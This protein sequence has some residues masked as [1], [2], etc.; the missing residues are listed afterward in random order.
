M[1]LPWG[2]Y[3]ATTTPEADVAPAIPTFVVFAHAI[4]DVRNFCL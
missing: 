3:L 4:C 1:T 2:E